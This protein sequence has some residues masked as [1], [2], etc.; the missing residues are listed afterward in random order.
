MN[1]TAISLL[2]LKQLVLPAGEGGLWRST[3]SAELYEHG[4]DFPNHD[5]HGEVITYEAQ[6]LGDGSILVRWWEGGGTLHMEVHDWNT[7]EAEFTG[8]SVTVIF[9]DGA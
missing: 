6:Y 9:K 3:T 7:K 8:R 5:D 1:I 2:D 4:L